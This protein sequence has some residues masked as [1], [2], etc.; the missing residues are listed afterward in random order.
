MSLSDRPVSRSRISRPVL[1]GFQVIRRD[2]HVRVPT[3]YRRAG[4]HRAPRSRAASSSGRGR[5]PYCDSLPLSATTS[6]NTTNSI[7]ISRD[8]FVGCIEHRNGE[9]ALYRWKLAQKFIKGLAA[10]QVIEKGA[11]WNTTNS[12]GK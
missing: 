12:I 4:M 10:F 9:F 1:I 2:A 7:R 5:P 6:Q 11:D 3:G 8:T